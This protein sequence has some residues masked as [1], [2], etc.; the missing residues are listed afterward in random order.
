M[1]HKYF[2]DLPLESDEKAEPVS[3]FDFLFES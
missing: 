2:E 3:K 1:K